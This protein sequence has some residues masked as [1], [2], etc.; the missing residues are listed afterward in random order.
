[1]NFPSKAKRDRGRTV[2][3]TRILEFDPE[4]LWTAERF[5]Q[6]F[7]AASKPNGGSSAADDDEDGIPADTLAVIRQ[8]VGDKDDRSSAFYSVV[9]VLKD[10]G[11]TLSHTVELLARYPNGIAA[12][13]RGRLHH[14]VERIWVKLGGEPQPKQHFQL[15]PFAL[16][17]DVS[18]V[19]LTGTV[20]VHAPYCM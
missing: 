12:K 19:R 17:G 18:T 9:R 2:A 14:E 16:P 13:Y 11:I 15:K 10:R 3:A 4:V 6:E 8:G 20:G 5:E 7:P 1:V